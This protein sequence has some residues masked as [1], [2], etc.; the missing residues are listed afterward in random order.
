[1]N[2]KRVVIT[3][4]GTVCAVGNDLPQTWD[5]LMAGRHGFARIESM[6]LTGH[7]ITVGG[8]VKNFEYPDKREAKR[9]DPFCQFGMVA[10]EEALRMSGI[11][12]GENVAPERVGI[13]LG[14]GIGGIRTLEREMVNGRENGYRRVSALLVPMIIINILSGN[15]AIKYG[16]KGNSIGMVTACSSGTH[17]IGEGWRAIKLG[18]EDVIIAGGAESPFAPVCVAGFANMKAMTE[19][20]DPDR[21][22]I[23]F[24]KE[25]SGF[26]MGEG[27]GAL[28]LEE[29]EHAKARGANI[30]AE[31]VGYG[32][33]TDAYHITQ[34]SPDGE[35]AAYAMNMAISSADIT[36]G[37]IS[38]INAHGT[39]TPM[40][41][42]FETRAIKTV[43]G[44]A[45]YKMPISSTKSMVGH[46]LGAAGALEAVFS[47]KSI[48]EGR[49]PPTVGYRVPDEELDLDY[50][51]DGARDVDVKY[52]LSNSLGFGGH[53]GTVIFKRYEG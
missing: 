22:S 27:A 24:D 5:S 30:L 9:L 1:M 10:V 14:S 18:L 32:T 2:E 12:A 34:P 53:N 44:D 52:A 50:V 26:V 4:L 13:Y 38:Y 8:E 49:I 37:D 41:D 31:V 33:S 39:S 7:K 28:V 25:R 16:F 46:A 51:T 19:T 43:F 6:D 45:A 47:V 15:V 29:L 21:A 48:M 20:T 36:P 40:N 3:G 11:V 35:G 42:L 17:T 23:P